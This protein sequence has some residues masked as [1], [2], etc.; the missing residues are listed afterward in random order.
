MRSFSTETTFGYEIASELRK[1]VTT[2]G[3]QEVRHAL[4]FARTHLQLNVEGNL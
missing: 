2:L 1:I 4:Q 3:E